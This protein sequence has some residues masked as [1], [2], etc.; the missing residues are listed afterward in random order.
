M[1]LVVRALGVEL[2]DVLR[3]GGPRREPAALRG[4]FQA[5]DRGIVARCVRHSRRNFVARQS[6][7][8]HGFGRQLLQLL[9][10][11]DGGGC[12]DSRIEKFAEARC[13]AAVM[14]PGIFARARRYLSGQQ[15]E[16]EAIFVSG[17]DRPI[18]PQE[19]GA[20]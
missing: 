14:L 20:G 10:L 16:Y 2:V 1:G 6:R 4:Y 15:G 9:L 17:P 3:S 19:A 7:S 5:T 13:K 11:L 8:L 18:A 12:V